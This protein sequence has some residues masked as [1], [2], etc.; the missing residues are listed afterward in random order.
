MKTFFT[1]LAFFAALLLTAQ[2]NT[3]L[4]WKYSSDDKVSQRSY[5]QIVPKA[6]KV[7]EL[8]YSQLKQH[9]YTAPNENNVPINQS[10]CIISL[11]APDGQ[12]QE[13]RVVES[14]VMAPELCASF[15]EIRTFAIQGIT[16]K[17]ATGK[18]DFTHFGFHAM[19]RSIN[20]DFFIDPY[21]A[22]NTQDYITYYVKDYEK[23]EEGKLP[24]VGVEGMATAPHDKSKEPFANLQSTMPPAPCVGSNLRTYRLAVACTGE[25]AVAVCN[26]SVPTVPLTLSKIVTSVNRVDG[27]YRTEVAVRLTLVPTTTNVIFL[28][29][30]TDPFNNTNATTLIGQSQTVITNTIGSANFDIGHTFSTGAGGL[31]GLGVVC[32]NSNKARGVT[33]SPQPW[34][35]PYDIDYV[36]HEI[37]HQFNGNHTFNALTNSCNGN[38]NAATSVE[39]GSGITIMGYAG[40][41]GATNNLANNSIAYFHAI[42]YDEIVNFV[43]T[44]AGNSCQV[45][46]STGNGAP[47]VTAPSSYVVPVNTPFQ[48][49]G[50]ATDPNG[51]PLTYSWEET[52]PGSSGGNWNS[53][54]KPF[55]RSYVPVN[56]PTRYFPTLNAVLTNSLQGF[57]GEYLPTTAQ[58][59]NFRLTARDNKATGGGVCYAATTITVN[60]SAGPFDVTY[61]SNTG[62]SWNSGSQQTITW[63]VNNTNL[64]PVSCANV[65]I[66]IS[67]NSGSTFSTLLANTPN[68]G[69]Q[70]ITVPTVSATISTCRIR[71]EAANNVF[72]DISDNN[73]TINFVPNV[74]LEEYTSENSFGLQ[75]FP[76]PATDFVKFEID[77]VMTKEASLSIYNQLGKLVYVQNIDK[78]GKGIIDLQNFSP[79]IYMLQV[80]NTDGK[81]TVKKLIVD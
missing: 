13:F 19:V 18:I 23:P 46:S 42:S 68:D 6:Y 10:G 73:F 30:A 21:S 20:G 70:L 38:R 8:Q 34:G 54:N 71:V 59:L 53:G 69:S 22:Y 47:V 43:T 48:L 27:V 60:A 16:D 32:S 67:Y 35:D 77:E 78:S 49:T 79:G 65:N 25:Y 61:P 9:L 3:S 56:T 39:P 26:P 57:K 28:D 41:C 75:I 7:Y 14:P 11:P 45:S 17:Y 62:I 51:D 29:G 5:R 31:A 72:Y 15:P 64:A 81:R 1:I 33:G 55:F 40:I 4:L 12:M 24:E 50:S 63:N 37:G 66:L 74:G 36:C 80:K 76:N 44:G 58:T 52:D 2:K